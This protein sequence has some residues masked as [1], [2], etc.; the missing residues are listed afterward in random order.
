MKN[1]QGEKFQWVTS[2]PV[3][4]G[5]SIVLP[6]LYRA[7]EG[8]EARPEARGPRVRLMEVVPSTTTGWHRRPW[9]GLVSRH[10]RAGPGLAVRADP[11][12]LSLCSLAKVKC[13]SGPPWWPL[14]VC[15]CQLTP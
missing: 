4:T 9:L 8:V 13:L 14:G 2:V 7:W 15:C 1:W 5:H 10:Q 3:G 11:V 6:Y 12:L